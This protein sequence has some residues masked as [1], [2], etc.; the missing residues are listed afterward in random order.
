MP[1]RY[2][3]A[4]AAGRGAVAQYYRGTCGGQGHHN[5]PETRG[6]EPYRSHRAIVA[7]VQATQTRGLA[8]SGRARTWPL[9]RIHR[10]TGMDG[11]RTA[12]AG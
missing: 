8:R 4:Q 1:A 11:V 6:R 2:T 7:A 3:E 5:A 9:A 10:W 12:E